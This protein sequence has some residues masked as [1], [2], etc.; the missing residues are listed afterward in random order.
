MTDL[1]RAQEQ[2]RTSTSAF[3][4]LQH[5]AVQDRKLAK[6]GHTNGHI[7]K[8]LQ[9][10]EKAKKHYEDLLHRAEALSN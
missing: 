8:A 1:E 6:D 10:L 9:E 3:E 5:L 2:V 4:Y 7:V